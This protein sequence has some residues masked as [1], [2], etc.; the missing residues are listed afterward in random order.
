MGQGPRKGSRS[1]ISTPRF[2]MKRLRTAP[3]SWRGPF[4]ATRAWRNA[5]RKIILRQHS[6][7]CYNSI[8]ICFA[9][10]FSSRFLR[11]GLRFFEELRHFVRA[12]PCGCLLKKLTGF[13]RGRVKEFCNWPIFQPCSQCNLCE[14]SFNRTVLLLCRPPDIM[15]RG[16]KAVT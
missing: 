3:V 11:C 4:F 12:F 16:A 5:L 14:H 8:T 13:R 7:A 1:V 10:R 15:R 2:V 6:C 9:G